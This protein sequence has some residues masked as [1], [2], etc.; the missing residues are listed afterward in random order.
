[1]SFFSLSFLLF[2]ATLL[3]LF[4]QS[5]SKT[6]RRALLTAANVA[7]LLTFA[8]T[9]PNFAALVAVVGLG[10]L[11]LRLVRARSSSRLAAFCVTMVIASLLY[12][13]RYDVLIVVLPER[14]L[15]HTLEIVGLSYFSFKLIHMLVDAY[16]GV[17][18][19]VSLVGYLN[20]HLGFVS[21]VAGPIQRYNDFHQFWEEIDAGPP[22]GRSGLLAWNRLLNGLV[23]IGL[24]A[25]AAT[26]VFDLSERRAQS[27]EILGVVGMFYSYPAYV[28]F[29]FAGYCDIVIGAAALIGLKHQENFDRPYL[30]RNLIDFWNRW[31]ISLTLWIR[32][33]VFMSSFKAV[34]TR[35]PRRARAV[36]YALLFVS[37]F[38]A[39][40][41][42]GPGR[43]FA[44][45]GFVHGIGVLVCQMYVDILR[46][47]LGRAGV[48]RYLASG[49]FRFGARALTFNYVCFS[50]LFFRPWV[51]PLMDFLARRT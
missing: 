31:H 39:G 2:V 43:N 20:Y 18:A 7:F 49:W 48:Q 17:L 4:H 25:S 23:K 32:D 35:W 47:R 11:A 42:H 19:P 45:F 21:L 40:V 15:A 22:D 51:D 1:M 5:R 24:L 13:K 26:L 29:N 14:A 10:Y 16:Q 33:Y 28:Y 27:G 36:G 6:F 37:L 41:W 46:G 12:L 44:A 50:F 3:L 34:A 30:A 38:L 9:L 8:T